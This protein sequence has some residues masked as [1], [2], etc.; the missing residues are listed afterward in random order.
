MN[1]KINM[2]PGQGIQG[3]VAKILEESPI[4]MSLISV[5]ARDRTGTLKEW[6][7]VRRLRRSKG[8]YFFV[9]V[10]YRLSHEHFSPDESGRL[11][12][13]I[14]KHKG[15]LD[16]TLGRKVGISVAT[17]DYLTNIHRTMGMP[18]TIRPRKLERVAEA[19]SFDPLTELHSRAS[20][21]RL[22]DVEL[23]RSERY[24][25]ELCL[26][27]WDVD[28]FKAVND[29]HGH[30]RGDEVLFR[31][32]KVI[33]ATCRITD[34]VGRYGGEEFVCLLPQT[35]PSEGLRLSERVRTQ[36]QQE[37]YTKYQVTVSGG[38]ASYPRD[39]C[40]VELLLEAADAA[41][42]KSKRKGKNQVCLSNRSGGQICVDEP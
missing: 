37:F 24:G 4:D 18:T 16:R 6:T 19:A 35:G 29:Q 23:R 20:F 25:K 10:L 12:Y 13:R 15:W 1:T 40:E 36:I 41:L 5:L 34:S 9:E 30:L 2:N 22:T 27:L 33:S 42:Y 39:A 11:W 21:L 3:D 31:V 28:D 17:L 32:G 7:Q 8:R 38:V 26:V 14:L